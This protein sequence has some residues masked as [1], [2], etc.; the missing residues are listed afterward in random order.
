[1]TFPTFMA[2]I[3]FVALA[4]GGQ[5]V[6]PAVMRAFA[7]G[8]AGQFLFPLVYVALTARAQLRPR[9]PTGQ[10]LLL[11]FG[12][13]GVG[14]AGV[15]GLY[16]GPRSLTAALPFSLCVAA[17]GAVWAWLY[18]RTQSLYAAWAS[19]A[20]IDAAIFAIGFDMVR[21]SWPLAA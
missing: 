17:G 7:A 16:A 5:D 6:N 4:G 13:G 15:V 2:W 3:Y 11:G 20:V 21:E 14:G 18:Y 19:H 8:K 1:M 12:F 10:G 9:P